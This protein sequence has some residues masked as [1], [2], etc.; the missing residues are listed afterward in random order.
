MEDNR[1]F[2]ARSLLAALALLSSLVQAADHLASPTEPD[3]A[4]LRAMELDE[5]DETD[6][7]IAGATVGKSSTG[8]VDAV[9]SQAETPADALKEKIDEIVDWAPEQDLDCD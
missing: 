8:D 3:D 6:G 7:A 9:K 4:Y 2:C 1:L 5:E